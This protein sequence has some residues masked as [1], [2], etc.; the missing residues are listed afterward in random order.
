MKQIPLSTPTMHGEEQ[1]FIQEAFDTNWVSSLGPHVRAFEKEITD[2]TGTSFAAALASG[3]A[4]IHLA[5]I[6]SG[7][8]AGDLV[9]SPSFTFSASVN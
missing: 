9:F 5:V 4:A 1:Q 8:K 7:V 3:T 2:Y 6:L